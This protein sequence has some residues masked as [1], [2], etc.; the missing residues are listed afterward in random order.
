M[1]RAYGRRMARAYTLRIELE[2]IRPV[3]WRQVV[4]P[5][6]LSLAR[7]HLVIQDA[8]GW[9][10]CHLHVFEVGERAFGPVGDEAFGSDVEDE[11]RVT[12]EKLLAA[13]DRFRYV[14]DMGD[15]WGHAIVVEKV[16]EAEE[17]I[18]PRCVAGARACPPEDCG[19]VWGYQDLLEA[20][21]RPRTE[22]QRELR[23]WVGDEWTPEAFD[24]RAADRLVARHRPR[25]GRA[26]GG[27]KVGSRSRARA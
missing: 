20:L 8:M 15:D 27:A 5:G 17:T 9:E 24:V 1:E 2:E 26:R 6:N 4:V 13:K 3:I 12:L 16:T 19:G 21:V 23:E 10:N 7:L 11:K 25:P 22:R 18:A 14:Y